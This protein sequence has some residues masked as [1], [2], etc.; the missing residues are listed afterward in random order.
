QLIF[1]FLPTPKNLSLY[2][3]RRKQKDGAIAPSCQLAIV[4]YILNP[5]APFPE[6]ERHQQKF[7]VRKISTT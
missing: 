4:L 5:H 6:G 2:V 7:F 3:L 1:D